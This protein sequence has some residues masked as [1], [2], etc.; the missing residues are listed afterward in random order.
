MRERDEAVVAVPELGARTG[1]VQPELGADSNAIRIEA[2]TINAPAGP[3]LAVGG[4]ADQEAAI[5]QAGDRG[6]VLT[7]CRVSIYAEFAADFGPIDIETLGVDAITAAILGRLPCHDEAAI[8]ER[9]DGG[10][11]LF[12]SREAVY[13]NLAAG[14]RAI[15]PISPDQDVIITAGIGGPGCDEAAARQSRYRGIYLRIQAECQLCLGSGRFSI[16]VE[17]LGENAVSTAIFVQGLPCHHK[18]TVRQK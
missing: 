12:R 16:F 4:P 18:T 13:E 3:I 5:V 10:I 11:F 14:R 2:L 1:L 17:N 6:V 7:I 8:V 15:G 9:R